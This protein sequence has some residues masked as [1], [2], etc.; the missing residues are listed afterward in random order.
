[1]RLLHTSELELEDFGP[2]VIPR[3]AILSHRWGKE[4]VTF[5]DMIKG[6][7]QTKTGYSKI[8]GSCKQANNDG[9]EYIWVDTCCINK[10][11]SAE[12]SEAINSMY[13]WYKN[14][15][16]C[17]AYLVDVPDEVNPKED[18]KFAGSDWFNRGWTLQE[19]LAPHEGHPDR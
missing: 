5:E 13:A 16:I 19:L 10:D 17:Y 14:A 6:L 4:E 7:A 2:S 9:Y 11:S 3:Y 15:G 8:E 12:L 18:A 1:M